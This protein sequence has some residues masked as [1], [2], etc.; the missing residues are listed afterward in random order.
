MFFFFFDW[1]SNIVL[2]FDP[3]AII[4]P[5]QLQSCWHNDSGFLP[6]RCPAYNIALQQRSG[7]CRSHGGPCAKVTEKVLNTAAGDIK[8]GFLTADRL[9]EAWDSQ[10]CQDD[11]SPERRGGNLGPKHPDRSI[12]NSS[13]TWDS[14]LTQHKQRRSNLTG[15][16]R[17]L[18]LCVCVCLV[19]FHFVPSYPPSLI[20]S[21][22]TLKKS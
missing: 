14:S 18:L 2:K 17:T 9:G 12:W 5:V 1:F 7:P 22:P 20:S 8:P 15:H 6:V 10:K 21:F 19:Q 4:L 3:G 11:S 13:G 16:Q